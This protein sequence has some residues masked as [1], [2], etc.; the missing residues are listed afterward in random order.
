METESRPI[1]QSCYIN[2]KTCRN[3]KRDDFDVDPQTG[4]KSHCN[5]WIKLVGMDPQTGQ[6]IDTW[7]CNEFAKIKLMLENSNQQRQTAASMDK[8]TNVFIQALPPIA[9][10]RVMEKYGSNSNKQIANGNGV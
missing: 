1:I 10:Q 2:G 4:E 9:A 5:K 7:C 6:Q 3:G 8:H